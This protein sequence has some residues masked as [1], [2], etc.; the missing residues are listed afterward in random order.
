MQ[1][2]KWILAVAVAA[3]LTAA[4]PLGAARA[5]TTAPFTLEIAGVTGVV[6]LCE[7]SPYGNSCGVGLTLV[8]NARIGIS[9]NVGPDFSINGLPAGDGSIVGV[10]PNRPNQLT[11]KVPV[12]PTTPGGPCGLT[13]GQQLTLTYTAT[14]TQ[15]VGWVGSGKIPA[16]SPQQVTFTVPRVFTCTWTSCQ[17]CTETG[18]KTI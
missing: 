13:P 9:S 7:N 18:C 11:F 15:Q 4:Y 5:Q 14:P 12:C 10:P 6:G 16:L 3:C 17:V 2:Y 1:A 8:Y